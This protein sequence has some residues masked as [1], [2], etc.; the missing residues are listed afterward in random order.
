MRRRAFIAAL[1]ATAAWPLM[2]RAQQSVMPTIG[3]LSGA[4]PGRSP[5]TTDRVSAFSE[6]LAEAG[7]FDGRNVAIE[8]RF[9]KGQY[10][11]LP[12]LAA[13]FVRR[14]ATDRKSVV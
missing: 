10:D 5:D 12:G 4:S 9:A 14:Q 11:Q 7:Y 6:G 13:E 1:G 2:A 8:Y 3:F